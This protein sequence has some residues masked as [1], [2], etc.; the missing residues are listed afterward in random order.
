MS[1]NCI[2]LLMGFFLTHIDGMIKFK[3][4]LRALSDEIGVGG[5]PCKEKTLKEKFG[6]RQAGQGYHKDTNRQKR[7]GFCNV[8]ILRNNKCFGY[9]LFF[10]VKGIPGIYGPVCRDRF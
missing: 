5:V 9:F 4:L 6:F 7:D 1:G 10:Y 3:R 2:G 8:K